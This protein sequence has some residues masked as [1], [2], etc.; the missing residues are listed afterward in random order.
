MMDITRI[1]MPQFLIIALVTFAALMAGVALIV[2]FAAQLCRL[3]RSP[4]A[5]MVLNRGLAG[6]LAFG[7]GWMAMA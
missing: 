4:R 6:L 1:E 7:G 5:M 3:A 2:G